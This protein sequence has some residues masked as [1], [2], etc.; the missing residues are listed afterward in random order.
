M[1]YTLLNCCVNVT[2][3]KGG[4]HPGIYYDTAQV[5]SRMV[6]WTGGIESATFLS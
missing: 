2:C 6:R 5:Q 1:Y 3:E 4:G